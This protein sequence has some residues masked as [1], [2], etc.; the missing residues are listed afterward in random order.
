MYQLSINMTIISHMFLKNNLLNTVEM[1]LA[2][3]AAASVV[4]VK[5]FGN[6]SQSPVK[7]KGAQ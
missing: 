6:H 5:C 1:L 3:A 4:S 7:T 2:T